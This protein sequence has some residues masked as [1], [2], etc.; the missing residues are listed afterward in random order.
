[1]AELIIP[2]LLP[3]A[4]IM[5]M[6]GVGMT[7][8]IKDFKQVAKF[9]KAFLL[10]ALC[11]L[12]L[13][14]LL[15]MGAVTIFQLSGALAVGLIIISLCPGG[16]TSNLF[17]YL[18]KGDAGL[19]VSLTAVI[20]FITPFTIPLV[21]SWALVWQE[22]DSASF[23]LPIISTIIKLFAISVLPV[24]IGMFLKSRLK[25]KAKKAEPWVRGI[26][27]AVLVLVIIALYIKLGTETVNAYAILTGPAC[28][29]LNLAGMLLGFGLSSLCKL[30]VPQR[31]CI[32]MEVGLQNGTIAL[33]LA[34]D[35]LKN[36]VMTIAPC[37]YSLWMMIP[38]TVVVFLSKRVKKAS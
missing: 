14:P 33:L 37:I 13:L 36:D 9:P 24:L 27:S 30:N 34:A 7:L 11:Q 28:I 19:S 16:V 38:A 17:T 4:L 2:I 31:V 12:I 22:V 1:M 23:S 25:E 15:A 29:A 21:L 8:E 10:G 32:T 35:I 6:T 18:A 26:S 5:V 20:G 3:V